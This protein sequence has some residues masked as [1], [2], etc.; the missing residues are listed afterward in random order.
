M[1][2]EEEITH[3]EPQYAGSEV[4]T[5]DTVARVTY[6]SLE[7]GTITRYLEPGD[8]IDLP[9]DRVSVEALEVDDGD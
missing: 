3:G 2:S 7:R 6:S 4:L 9:A 1:P 8:L 5:E